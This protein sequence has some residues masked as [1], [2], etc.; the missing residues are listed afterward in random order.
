MTWSLVFQGAGLQSLRSVLLASAPKE[1]GAILLCNRSAASRLLVQTVLPAAPD[2]CVVQA[3]DQLEFSAGYLAR[4]VKTAREHG[5]SIILAHTHPFSRWPMFSSADDRGEAALMPALAMRSPLG[6]HGALVLGEEGFQGRVYVGGTVEPI[7]RVLEIGSSVRSHSAAA[8]LDVSDDL[9]NRNVLALGELGQSHLR[10]LEVAVVG[11]GGT[12]SVVAQ[13]LAHL[14]IGR[15]R[16][17]DDD[18]LETTNLNRVVG[19]RPHDVG[20]LKV[21]AA[22]EYL[23]GITGGRTEI[24]A[25]AGNVVDYDVGAGLLAAD[26]VFGCTDTHGSRAVINQLAY[27]HLLPAIDMGLRIDARNGRITGMAGR[28]QM[29]APGLACLQCQSLLDPEAVRRDLLTEAARRADPYIVGQATPEPAVISLNSVVS[30]LAVTMFLAAVTG[31]PA[32]ARRLNYRIAEGSVRPVSPTPHPAC[33]VCSSERG[34]VARGDA[35]P[36]FWRTPT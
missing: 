19:A 21:E 27:Q 20:R 7:A 24:E 2:D 35:W 8:P 17:I 12:G 25:V 31:F 3:P 15:L 22:A 16:L 28:V 26:F 14:G 33:I 6:V 36:M 29:L 1:A 5:Q 34:A 13:Q 32:A 10:R 9:Y 4:A 18:R 11:L 30:S 23:R